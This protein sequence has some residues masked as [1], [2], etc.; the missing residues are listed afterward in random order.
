MKYFLLIIITTLSLVLVSC[1]ANIPADELEQTCA[2]VVE[3]VKPHET[4]LL[5]YDTEKG[6][7]Q[8]EVTGM[9]TNVQ[10]G[11]YVLAYYHTD[12]IVEGLVDNSYCPQ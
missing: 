9:Y 2:E 7:V 1:A 11:D 3:V 4:I 6:F 10:K 5:S 8:E 12:G